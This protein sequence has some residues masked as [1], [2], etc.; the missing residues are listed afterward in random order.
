MLISKTDSMGQ[1]RV[2][3]VTWHDQTKRISRGFYEATGQQIR[4]ATQAKTALAWNHVKNSKSRFTCPRNI[5]WGF[6]SLLSNFPAYGM[7]VILALDFAPKFQPVILITPAPAGG[8]GIPKWN[9]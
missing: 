3:S 6:E 7:A 8:T 9:R 5:C 2:S 4:L 1:P